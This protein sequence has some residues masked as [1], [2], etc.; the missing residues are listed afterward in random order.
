MDNEFDKINLL[1]FL[2]GI[3]NDTKPSNVNFEI[4]DNTALV[5]IKTIN[6]LPVEYIKITVS[7][8]G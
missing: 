8:Q 4:V 6:E 2:E 3:I 5:S 1:I 7:K